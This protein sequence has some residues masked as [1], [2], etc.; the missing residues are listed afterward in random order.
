MSGRFSRYAEFVA[1]RDASPDYFK[2]VVTS[3][4]TPDG[5][6]KRF[7]RWVGN[8]VALLAEEIRLETGTTK[9][10]EGRVI[11]LDAATA[12]EALLKARRRKV[13]QIPGGSP[14]LLCSFVFHR[15]EKP[16]ADIRDVWQRP[17]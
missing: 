1:V 6:R 14:T 15:N 17:A 11:V 8:Q 10:D 9:N 3:R 7:F 13:A 12:L 16:L 2:P 5:A 4:T